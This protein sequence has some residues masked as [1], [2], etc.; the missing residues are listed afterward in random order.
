MK[1]IS[2]F[3][4]VI[5]LVFSFGITAVGCDMFG[6]NVVNDPNNNENNG[7]NEKDGNDD[8]P[9]PPKTNPYLDL[10]SELLA[11]LDNLESMEDYI[12]TI[13]Y[14]LKNI[15]IENIMDKAD[16]LIG[17]EYSDFII[18][19]FDS[20]L[21]MLDFVADILPVLPKIDIILNAL[22]SL[23]KIPGF[24]VGTSLAK[25]G[26]VK[27]EDTY[28]FNH[29]G[30]NYA[31]TILGDNQYSIVFDD[32]TLS[33]NYINENNIKV[34]YEDILYELLFDEQDKS[35]KLEGIDISV[36]ADPLILLLFESV[37]VDNNFVFQFFD[38]ESQTLTQLKT[39][40]ELLE[41]TLS[42]Q[43]AVETLPYSILNEIPEEFA[44]EGELYFINSGLLEE[45][46]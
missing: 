21:K 35:L 24:N 27:D 40:I 25:L 31:V 42:L 36:E 28:S 6:S 1:R 5:I 16:S 43:E 38:R 30:T 18:E 7:N 26:I 39:N 4:L 29:K 15:P 2:T 19:N 10:I 20:G 37:F 9:P 17:S 11:S 44:T 22:D 23:D 12:R 13:S 32:T 3:I 14:L 8:P 41:A 46:L 34:I 45:F 33:L